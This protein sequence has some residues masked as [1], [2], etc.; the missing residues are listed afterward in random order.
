[1]F[2]FNA[3]QHNFSHTWKKMIA[4]FNE[5]PSVYIDDMIFERVNWVR[6]V[7]TPTFIGR[8]GKLF[9][10]IM[11]RRM[12]TQWWRMIVLKGFFSLFLFFVFSSRGNRSNLWWGYL[13]DRLK[14]T[15]HVIFCNIDD[16]ISLSHL[17]NF[18]QLF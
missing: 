8:N 13:I 3:R 10:Q 17:P 18:P 16:Q 7:I 2:F 9:I 5:L 6:G 1:M 11:K 14:N 12:R 15:F 4:S